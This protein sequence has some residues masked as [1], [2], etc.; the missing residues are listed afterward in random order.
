[1][2]ERSRSALARSASTLSIG[3]SA[4]AWN[5]R[6]LEIEIDEVATPLPRRVEGRVRVHLPGLCRYNVALDAAGRHRW[7][8][9]SACARVEVEMRSPAL[10]WQGSAYFDSNE[11]DEPIVTPFTRWDWL[12]APLA[13][14]STAVVYDVQPKAGPERV[15]AARF[16]PDGRAE[17]FE[18]APR[19]ALPRSA[20]RVA[21]AL[22]SDADAAAP[23]ILRTLEDT[24]F[25]ARSLI[26]TTLC[27]ERVTAMHESISLPRLDSAAVRMLLPW[28][29]PRVT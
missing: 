5:G 25:Y 3:P 21:R 17:P 1:M 13:D 22:R 11:G 9:I 14:G 7:G 23:R 28:R 29:M 8:P 10:R 26:D 18:A 6:W 24:P 15:I 19:R 27:G 20:W 16:L 2:T 12:R 4:L